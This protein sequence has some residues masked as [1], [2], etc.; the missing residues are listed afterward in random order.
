MHIWSGPSAMS[1]MCPNP[2]TRR[3]TYTDPNAWKSVERFTF[4]KFTA[5]IKQFGYNTRLN[6]SRVNE[7]ASVE[8]HS[9]LSCKDRI[10]HHIAESTTNKLLLFL[11]FTFIN[12]LS[13]I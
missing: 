11:L 3:T 2:T 13:S 5:A 1:R 8:E 6:M 4:S 7:D 10:P 9:V 12:L